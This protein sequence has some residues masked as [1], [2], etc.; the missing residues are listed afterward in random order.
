MSP[1]TVA[2]IA[3][4]RDERILS[5]AQAEAFGRVARGDLLSIRAELRLMLYAGVLLLTSG[6]G[7]FLKENHDRIG[8]AAIAAVVAAAAAACL[9]YA[10][11]RTPPFSW[12]AVPSTHVAAD[13]VLLL[14]M[15]LLGADLAYVESQFRVLG[16]NWAY[17]LLIVA[18]IYLV[19]AY[20]FDSRAVLTLALTSFAAWR[21]VAVGK[22]FGPSHY[23]APQ[24]SA[25]E[26]R[27][28]AIAVGLLYIA[29]GIAS[30]RTRRK[31]HFEPV[32]AG[33]GMILLFG[34]VLSGAL[35]H[36]GE[37][38][39][40]EA[41]LVLLGAGA[42]FA[43]W[44]LRR[45]LEFAIATAALYIGGFRILGEVLDGQGGL[46]IIAAWSTAALVFLIRSTRRLRQSE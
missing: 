11:R 33:A 37:W 45:P 8:P 24:A 3:R 29:V 40:W 22:P 23:G 44:R 17:H 34:G 35:E 20:R 18:V 15:L 28:N 25:E 1:E 27:I 7:I 43:C 6:A 5:D 36:G 16:P 42:L 12:G 30:A 10:A 39:A 26:V 41:A 14:S 2:A 4:L 46:L 21:G 19:A 9:W 13:Y 38:V 32:W 31:A